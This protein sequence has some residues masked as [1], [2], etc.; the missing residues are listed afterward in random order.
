MSYQNLMDVF[1][2]NISDIPDN[3]RILFRKAFGK[4]LNEVDS[5]TLLRFYSILPNS[6][7]AGEEERF[8]FSVSVH[9][10]WD[11]N[12]EERIALDEAIWKYKQ[13]SILDGSYTDSFEKRIVTIMDMR[14]DDSGMLLMKLSQIIKFLKTKGLAIDG[15]EL[16]SDI[17]RWNDKDRIIQKRWAKTYNHFKE[18]EQC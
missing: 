13:N 16:L 15:K 17:L 4:R 9:C 6:I 5:K 8:L 7:R 1:F 2:E 14:W 11:E 3:D 18:E 10:L 12:G